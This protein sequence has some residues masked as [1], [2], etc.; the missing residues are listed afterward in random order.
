MNLGHNHSVPLTVIIDRPPE[1]HPWLSSTVFEQPTLITIT[2]IITSESTLLN[3]SCLLC[4][5]HLTNRQPST[6]TKQPSTIIYHHKIKPELSGSHD[7]SSTIYQ[8]MTTHNSPTINRRLII[9]HRQ[10]SLTNHSSFTIMTH[11]PTVK[12]P[13]THEWYP[14]T[15][16]TWTT[17][18]QQTKHFQNAVHHVNMAE[19]A[20][21]VRGTYH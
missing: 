17:S 11:Q 4:N 3:R 2:V 8:T 1:S 7:N 16:Q 12:P 13:S 5:I 19:T 15:M 9:A 6:E 14:T 18:L 21:A 10:P 20:V